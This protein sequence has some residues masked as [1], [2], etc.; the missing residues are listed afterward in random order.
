MT[1]PK[2]LVRELADSTHG[3]CDSML[4]LYGV[5]TTDWST[6]SLLRD[7]EDGLEEWTASV[8]TQVPEPGYW[9]LYPI[10]QHLALG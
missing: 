5:E 4:A 9:F 10:R 2:I 1:A 7:R 8:Q 6:P 3:V